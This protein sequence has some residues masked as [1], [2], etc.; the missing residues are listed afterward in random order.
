MQY[1]Y[2]ISEQAKPICRT[3]VFTKSYLINVKLWLHIS[4]VKLQVIE[5]S[6]IKRVVHIMSHEISFEMLQG[7]HN[8]LSDEKQS[9]PAAG[10]YYIWYFIEKEYAILE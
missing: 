10:E 4:N 3:V 6:N 2:C 7:Y 1:P 8:T 9:L 5:M